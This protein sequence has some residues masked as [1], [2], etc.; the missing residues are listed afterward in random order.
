MTTAVSRSNKEFIQL[1]SE[2]IYWAKSKNSETVINQTGVGGRN[3]LYWREV[4]FSDNASWWYK[5]NMSHE[6]L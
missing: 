6:L 4:F 1:N 2:N 5:K 3:W